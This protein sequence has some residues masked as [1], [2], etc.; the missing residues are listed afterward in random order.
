MPETG[1]AQPPSGEPTERANVTVVF[2]RMSAPPLRPPVRL[3]PGV[4]IRRERIGLEDYRQLYN[5]VGGPWL[6]WLR[7]VMPDKVLDKHLASSTVGVHLLRVKGEVAGFFELDAGYW[8]LVNLN[9]FGL[10]L[11]FIGR[12]LGGLLLDYAVDEVFSSTSPLRGMSV[13]TCNADHPRAL[14]NYLAAGFSEYRRVQEA[15][16]I[17]V[18]LGFKIPDHLKG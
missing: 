5:E 13:N 3:P 4:S 10:R 8:P 9:Y 2:L 6:W 15:W 16:D 1:Y 17:P 14:P 18:R 7:R 11:P 12:G